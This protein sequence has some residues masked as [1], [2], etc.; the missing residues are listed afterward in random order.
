MVI[1]GTPRH[2]RRRTD[3]AQTPYRGLGDSYAAGPRA[4]AATESLA[5]CQKYNGS[6]P[7]RFNSFINDG[8][9][10]ALENHLACT[11]AI[12]QEV[13]GGQNMDPMAD[14]VGLW[15]E[16]KHRVRP[17]ANTSRSQ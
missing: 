7:Y 14:L 8:A 1:G 12:A 6:Y 9:R 2:I 4:G 5:V 3:I 15:R 10:L 16:R 11:G 17:S 13:Q